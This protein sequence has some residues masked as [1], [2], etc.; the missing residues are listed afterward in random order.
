ML[1]EYSVTTNM[2]YEQSIKAFEEKLTE[3]K[4]GVLC[5]LNLPDKFKEKGL[6]FEGKF[7]IFEICNPVEA[8]NALEKNSK[9]AY[10]LPC[11]ILIHERDGVG[12]VEM[13]KPSSMISELN[14]ADLDIMAHR[15]DEKL[16]GVMDSMK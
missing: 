4:F 8:K 1:Q 16:I 11:K 10:F 7:T 2:S 12:V 6:D 5:K 9:V 15:I 14:D 3:I 13:L